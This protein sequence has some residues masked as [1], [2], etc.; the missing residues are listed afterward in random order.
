MNFTTNTLKVNLMLIYCLL[1]QTV[2]FMKLKMK[3]F[4]RIFTKTKICLILV[5]IH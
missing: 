3:M 1:I 5:I 2:W 4:M